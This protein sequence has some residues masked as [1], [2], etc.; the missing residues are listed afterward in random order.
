MKFLVLTVLPCRAIIKSIQK[1]GASLKIN[2]QTMSFVLLDY[3]HKNKSS[4]EEDTLLTKRGYNYENA[5]SFR[6]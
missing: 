2:S 6:P 3:R 5:L 4:R 1:C